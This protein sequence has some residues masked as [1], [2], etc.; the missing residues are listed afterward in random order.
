MR[1]WAQTHPS[2]NHT[3]TPTIGE[4]VRVVGMTGDDDVKYNDKTGVVALIPDDSGK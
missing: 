1:W 2:V 4:R 3:C